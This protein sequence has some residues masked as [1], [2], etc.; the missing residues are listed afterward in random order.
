[1]KPLLVILAAISG[2]LGFFIGVV[3][4][5]GGAIA[6]AIGVVFGLGIG[7]STWSKDDIE[8]EGE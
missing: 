2:P 8:S 4:G 3:F 6:Y 1:M 7:F 5:I